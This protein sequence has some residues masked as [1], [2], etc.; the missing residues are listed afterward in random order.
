[1]QTAHSRRI[2]DHRIRESILETGDRNLYP[3]LE[4][5]QSRAS[6]AGQA[7]ATAS[8]TTIRSWVHRGLP[9]VATSELVAFDR[10]ALISEIHA[11]RQRTTLLAAVVGL[12][13]A[14]LRVS[15]NR[16]DYERYS[17]DESK[18]V[19]LRSV[20]ADTVGKRLASFAGPRTGKQGIAAQLG[21]S[22]LASLGFEISPLAPGRGRL[23][24]RRPAELPAVEANAADFPGGREHA[25]TG[26]ERRVSPHV[27]AY[28]GSPC[29]ADRSCGRVAIDLVSRR[30]SRK[31]LASFA[32]P[33]MA[34]KLAWRRPR[35]R[36][37]PAKPKIGIRASAPGEMLHVDV[38][39]IRLLDGTRAYLHAAIDNYSRRI[40]SW[41]LEERLGS[42]GTCR[43]LR[44]AACQLRGGSRRTAVVTD[45][46]CE[47]VNADVDN[48]LE[49][50]GL[51]RTLAQVDITFSNSM[52][53]AFWR[54]LKHSWLYLHSLESIESLHRLVD[55]YVHQHNE[56]MPHAAF[57]GP[58]P[59]EMYFGRGDAVVVKLAATR[60]K[61][62]DQR[63]EANRV[64]QCGVCNS[65]TALPALQLQRPRSRMS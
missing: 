5:P 46:G 65:D 43:L 26:R 14:M 36:L 7:L 1:M 52:I 24:P 4:I 6:V 35:R 20:A 57:E 12:L 22:S 25:E 54:S 30:R 62:R 41:S 60:I 63:I 51:R 29:S 18:A 48:L 39:I 49:D 9:D 61:A 59:D 50:E 47:N 17:D 42:G 45:A 21:T 33:R 64:V 32:G 38:T 11:L 53:E 23:R 40:L 8:A 56:V 16:L 31:R 44:E 10:V 37:Y 28:D 55:F 34:R 13:V 19:L 27:T 2:Y 58:T 15:K 3:E